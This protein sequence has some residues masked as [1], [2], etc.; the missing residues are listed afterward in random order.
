MCCG[1][2]GFLHI[3]WVFIAGNMKERGPQQPFNQLNEGISCSKEKGGSE[4]Q[5]GLHIFSTGKESQFYQV[6]RADFSPGRERPVSQHEASDLSEGA[7]RWWEY[8]CL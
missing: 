5:Y 6:T 2:T 1:C 4:N 7:E 8:T 3:L